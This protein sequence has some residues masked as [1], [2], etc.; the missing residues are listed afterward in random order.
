M[1]HSGGEGGEIVI[2]STMYGGKGER[3]RLIGMGAVE[4]PGELSYS[5]YSP[6][7]NFGWR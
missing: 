7:P 2:T 3:V 4:H 5:K 6:A 1:T